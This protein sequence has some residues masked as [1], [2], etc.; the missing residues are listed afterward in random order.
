MSDMNSE[1]HKLLP[2]TE[3]IQKW[4][5]LLS[6]DIMDHKVAK[7]DMKL[8]HIYTKALEVTFVHFSAFSFS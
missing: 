4:L 8:R 2:Y 3:D 7:T 5:I 6:E 1:I